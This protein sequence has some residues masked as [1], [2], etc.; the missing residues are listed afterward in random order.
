MVTR[1]LTGIDEVFDKGIL[2]EPKLCE[3]IANLCKSGWSIGAEWDFVAED[4][5]HMRIHARVDGI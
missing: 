3:V 5:S 4:I 2:P 1:E